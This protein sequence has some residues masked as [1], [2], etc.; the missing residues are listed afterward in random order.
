MYRL[1]RELRERVYM[2]CV[3]GVYDDEV[4]IRCPITA[5]D[6]ISLLVREHAGQHSYRWI[7]DPIQSILDVPALAVE[8][9]RELLEAYYWTRTFK[10]SHREVTMVERFLTTDRYGLG[11]IPA[12]YV[13]RLHLSVR[14]ALRGRQVEENETLRA[15]ESFGA[16]LTIR[17]EVE[18]HV[19]FGEDFRVESETSGML[20]ENESMWSRVSKVVEGLRSKG[21]R[22]KSSCSQ[23]W[24]E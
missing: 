16:L 3:R 23:A 18:I 4:I 12:D 21:L 1:P 11:M 24:H 5:M 8:V 6:T 10:F 15:I 17:T 13:R 20:E 22:I 14:T 7:E 2:F 19:G 9:A